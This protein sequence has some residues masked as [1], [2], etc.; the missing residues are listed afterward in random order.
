MGFFQFERASA[1]ATRPFKTNIL[2]KLQCMFYN[3]TAHQSNG[4]RYSKFQ[5]L[6]SGLCHFIYQRMNSIWL[7][8]V[9]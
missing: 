1:R 8:L 5:R 4:Q 9:A 7:E 3:H 6:I 2:T